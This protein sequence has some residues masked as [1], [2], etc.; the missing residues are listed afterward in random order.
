M[1]CSCGRRSGGEGF[2]DFAFETFD[3]AAG[4]FESAISWHD[5]AWHLPLSRTGTNVLTVVQGDGYEIGRSSAPRR[6]RAGSWRGTRSGRD[7]STSRSSASHRWGS[8]TAWRR[9]STWREDAS[10]ASP[11]GFR[12]A[13]TAGPIVAL[14]A[15][16]RVGEVRRGEDILFA[17]VG[18]GISVG[19]ALY[20]P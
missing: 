5:K 16:N 20:Q 1:R 17:T 10:R 13:H 6:R 2:V 8:R 11:T 3:E 14:D 19:L 15:A 12:G 18:A 7:P 4:H 9:G